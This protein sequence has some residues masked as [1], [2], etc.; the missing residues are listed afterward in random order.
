MTAYQAALTGQPAP[1][2]SGGVTRAAPGSVAALISSYKAS[3]EFIALRETSKAQ[4]NNRLETIREDHGHRTVTG[5]SRE[6]IVVGILQ[7]YADR[8]GAALDTLKKLRILIRHAINIGMLKHDPSLGIKR[9]KLQRIRS[10]TDDEIAIYR[11]K[12]PLGTK[13]RLAFELFACTGQRRSDVVRVA[14]SHIADNKIMV[15]QQ[16]TGRRLMIPLHGDLV[17]A[18]AAAPRE[19]VAILTTAYGRPFTVDG[20]SQWMRDAITSAGLPLECQPHGLRKATGRRLA[21]AGATAK[22]VMS[23]LGHTTL[24]EAERYT[25]EADQ[26]GLA[27]DAVIRLQGHKANRVTQTAPVSLGKA[28]KEK[29]KST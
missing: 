19:H 3:A 7:P 20:F 13:Q 29:G 25:E 12:W 23:I 1:V 9:P 6:R 17:A 15:V 18:L 16:K 26:A 2:A 5:L 22:M 14:W 21:E 27:E 4:Y 11:K 8:P 10:W 24:A 28:R